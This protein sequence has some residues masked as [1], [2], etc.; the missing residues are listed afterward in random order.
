MPD[1][2]AESRIG[3]LE[4]AVAELQ[5][6]L[7][8]LDAIREIEQLKY[9]YWRA[10]DHKDPSAF[11][12]C[13]VESGADLD[14]GVLGRF[15]DREA[16]VQVFSQIALARADGRWLVHDVH[17]GKHPSVELLDD[18]TATG[19]WT[20]SFMQLRPAEGVMLQSAMEYRDRYVI[21]NG[22]WRIQ[23]SQVTPLTSW[24]APLP[25]GAAVG[26]GVAAG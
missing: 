12:D 9:R 23:G 5:L 8:R 24:S 16:L 7:R 2:S 20:L 21:E 17:H 3:M 25:P 10:C 1:S 22:C 19:Q 15:S 6:R 4:A 26:P 14:Y 11:R 13:F 18:Q